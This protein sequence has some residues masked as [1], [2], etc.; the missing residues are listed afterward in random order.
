M[1]YHPALGKVQLWTAPNGNS[2]LTWHLS[3]RCWIHVFTSFL[4]ILFSIAFYVDFFQICCVTFII[5][6]VYCLH[7]IG[8]LRGDSCFPFS[9]LKQNLSKNLQN[10]YWMHKYN[11]VIND[12][13]TIVYLCFLRV[14]CGKRHRHEKYVVNYSVWRLL[15]IDREKQQKIS[16]K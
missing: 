9:V 10:K 2:H 13:G 15:R 4:L 1:Y 7:T 8:C 12:R 14:R 16:D 5:S 11:S 6:Y 3:G